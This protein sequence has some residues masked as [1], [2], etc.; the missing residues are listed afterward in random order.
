MM[1]Y[2]SSNSLLLCI[3]K[4]NTK[5]QKNEKL[6]PPS[7]PSYS[8]SLVANSETNNNQ[9]ELYLNNVE[10]QQQPQIQLKHSA[11]ADIYTDETILKETEEKAKQGPNVDLPTQ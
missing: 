6:E 2:S 11:F 5:L 8:T 1:I 7:P 10:Q 4:D 3:D 9:T